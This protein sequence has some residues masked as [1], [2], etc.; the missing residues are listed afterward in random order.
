MIEWFNW[1]R[2]L[3]AKPNRVVMGEIKD[4]EKPG[5]ESES[6]PKK[7]PRKEA[8]SEAETGGPQGPEP[9]RY[10]DWERKGRCVD[11]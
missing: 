6:T 11:F 9:T 7:L 2:D 8:G 10:G 4:D 5:V 3:K 1:K